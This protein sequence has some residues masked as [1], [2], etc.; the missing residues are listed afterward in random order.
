[1]VGQAGK[2]SFDF[3]QPEAKFYGAGEDKLREKRAHTVQPI[4]PFPD[5]KAN[6]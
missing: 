1:M 5:P 3:G 4:N 6:A 2:S